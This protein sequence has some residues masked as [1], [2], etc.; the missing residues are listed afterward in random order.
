MNQTYSSS[1]RPT[2]TALPRQAHMGL[3]LWF[4]YL[5]LL[6][7]QLPLRAAPVQTASQPQRVR[8]P[9]LSQKCPVDETEVLMIVRETLIPNLCLFNEIG[10]VEHIFQLLTWSIQEI[11]GK[12]MITWTTETVKSEQC[13]NGPQK[14]HEQSLLKWKTDARTCLKQKELKFLRI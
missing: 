7:W 11:L 10:K 5:L 9:L 14:A 2:P 12:K 6:P 3:G 8:L 13:Y 4:G 1:V